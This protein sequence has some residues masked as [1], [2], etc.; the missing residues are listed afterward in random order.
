MKPFLSLIIPVY[1]A[2]EFIEACLDSVFSQLPH[3]V[4]VIL[5]NDGTP[6]GSMEIVRRTFSQW[7][8]GGRLLVLEQSNKGPG[9]ARNTGIR[10]SRGDFIAFLDSDDVLLDGYFKEILDPTRSAEA[11]IIEF[12][13]KRFLDEA[14]IAKEPYRPLYNFHGLQ[15]L[16]NVREEVFAVGLWFPSTRIYRREIFERFSFPEGTHY[17]DLMLL[18]SIYKLNL[19][20]YFIDRPL[21]GYRYNPASITSNHTVKQFHEIYGFYKSISHENGCEATKILKLKVA[22]SIVFFSSEMKILGFQ[23][24]EL[25]RDIS[26]L[27][28]SPD[29]RSKLSRADKIFL[30]APRIYSALDALRVP[31]KK[32]LFRAGAL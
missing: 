3:G 19:E 11:D 27:R 4:E 2:E 7:I 23:L 6:D 29:A 8:A 26:R 32:L 15:K 13:F 10:R 18:S 12:G 31:A 16:S 17:E 20:I 9:A 21:L 30:R 22:R 24:D 25:V 5:V 28:L 14:H 1:K